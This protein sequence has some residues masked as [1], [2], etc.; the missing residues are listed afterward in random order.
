MAELLRRE[1]DKRNHKQ[2]AVAEVVGMDQRTLSKWESGDIPEALIWFRNLANYYGVSADY[3]L[4]TKAPHL[5]SEER[6][7]IELLAQLPAAK[8]GAALAV[9]KAAV[10]LTQAETVDTAAAPAN[11]GGG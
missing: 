7:A 4:G 6:A 9:L 3:L 1:R 5:S 2:T 11:V 8:R 10:E